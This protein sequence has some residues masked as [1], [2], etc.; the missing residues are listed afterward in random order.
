MYIYIYTYLIPTIDSHCPLHGLPMTSAV[1]F[2]RPGPGLDSFPS[3][4]SGAWQILAAGQRR[5]PETAQVEWYFHGKMK[6]PWE[7][8]WESMGK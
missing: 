5:G 1:L 7:N 4:W 3:E 8:P 2:K 6:N